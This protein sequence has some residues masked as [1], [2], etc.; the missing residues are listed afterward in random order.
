MTL[1]SADVT[2]RNPSHLP[3]DLPHKASKCIITI[4]QWQIPIRRDIKCNS[5]LPSLP[6]STLLTKAE[7]NDKNFTLFLLPN[8]PSIRVKQPREQCSL[9]LQNYC[10]KVSED[11]PRMHRTE[12]A[13]RRTALGRQRCPRIPAQA[14]RQQDP[15]V[16]SYQLNRLDLACRTGSVSGKLQQ[17]ASVQLLCSRH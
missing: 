4:F 11:P 14:V 7:R 10:R 5:L 12:A 6:P 17:T 13:P 9:H 1:F 16:C 15:L 2:Q 3:S 8:S